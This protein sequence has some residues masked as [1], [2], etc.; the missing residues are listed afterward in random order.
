MVN[1]GGDEV[2]TA[3]VWTDF[4]ALC[5]YGRQG[6]LL[7]GWGLVGVGF[8]AGAVGASVLAGHCD[9]GQ[10]L[11]LVAVASSMYTALRSCTVCTVMATKP[12]STTAQTAATGSARW[13]VVASLTARCC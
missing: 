2:W 8:C 13:T 3:E 6:L 10:L 7:R 12:R 9:S 1:P 4:A 11:S 5:L